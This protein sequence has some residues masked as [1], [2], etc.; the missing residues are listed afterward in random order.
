MVNNRDIVENHVELMASNDGNIN[1]LTDLEELMD[2]VTR[3]ISRKVLGEWLDACEKVE[4]QPT[5]KCRDCGK[6]ANYVS[7]R[8]GFVH[9]QYGLIRYR[10]AYYVCPHC[11]QSTCP[12][13]ERLNPIESLARMRAKIA[14]GKSLPVAEMASAWDLGSLNTLEMVPTTLGHDALHNFRSS[15]GE[16]ASVYPV[17]AQNGFLSIF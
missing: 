6:D 8:V 4:P 2:R 13:D 7:K 3:R 5:T 12:L 11:H 1:S 10:R 17:D 16:L 9:T 15:S 14:A